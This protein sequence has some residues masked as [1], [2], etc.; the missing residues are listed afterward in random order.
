[1]IGNANLR[2]ISESTLYRV[3][4]TDQDGVGY[5]LLRFKIAHAAV[6]CGDAEAALTDEVYDGTR[7]SGA[8]SIA[9]LCRR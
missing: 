9:T 6:A 5:L 2:I 7:L 1:M 3:T 8:D 4:D